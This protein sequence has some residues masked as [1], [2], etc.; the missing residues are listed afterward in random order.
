MMSITADSPK[1][2]LNDKGTDTPGP[3]AAGT[4]HR[5]Q[6]THV[7]VI[8]VPFDAPGEIIDVPGR[9]LS[10]ANVYASQVGSE[11]KVKVFVLLVEL[12][13]EGGPAE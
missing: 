8:H 4:A 3:G 11:G 10:S 5:A 12:D 7:T 2:M 9:I 1:G 6:H 13:I